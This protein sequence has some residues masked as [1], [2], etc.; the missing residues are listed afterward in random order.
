MVQDANAVLGTLYRSDWGRIIATLIRLFDDFDLAEEAA[1]EAF[2][3]AVHEWRVSG[4]PESPRAWLI[5][6]ARHKAID[7]IRRRTL[8]EEKIKS[9][10]ASGLPQTAHDPDYDPSEIP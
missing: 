1:Q 2:A 10:A 9:Y 3:A 8:H 6:T 7:R 5:Q 4:I